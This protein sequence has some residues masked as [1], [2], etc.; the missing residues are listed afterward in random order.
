MSANPQINLARLYFQL[1][2][3]DLAREAFNRVIVSFPEHELL[4]RG[5]LAKIG[6]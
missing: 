4:V 2:K 6:P 5:Y 3:G 1:G